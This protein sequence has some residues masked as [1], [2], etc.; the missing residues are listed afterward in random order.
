ME[1]RN[2]EQEQL[3]KQCNVCKQG[4]YVLS[5]EVV[6]EDLSSAENSDADNDN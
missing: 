6:L 4:E 1:T 5:N 2:S 3:V